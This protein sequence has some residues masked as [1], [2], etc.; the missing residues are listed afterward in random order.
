MPPRGA[1]GAT[2]RVEGYT[3]LMKALAQAEKSSRK[4]VRDE[5][6]QAGDHVRVDAGQKFTRYDARTAAGYRTRVR[7]RGVEVEQSL[8]KTTGLRPKFGALQMRK[9]LVPALNENEDE[10]A[11]AID[12]ALDRI[13]DRFNGSAA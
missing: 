3:Q 1:G 2:Q 4:A 11:R 12:A 10:T 9:A 7:Q 8:R 13:A 6:R 5:L